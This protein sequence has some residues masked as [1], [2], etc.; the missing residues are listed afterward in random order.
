GGDFHLATG[1]DRYSATSGDFLM[2]MDTRIEIAAVSSMRQDG[3]GTGL[4]VG[5]IARQHISY[6]L[7]DSVPKVAHRVVE[8]IPEL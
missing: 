8:N 1:G 3:P 2:A 6:V 5:I 4:V 7:Q